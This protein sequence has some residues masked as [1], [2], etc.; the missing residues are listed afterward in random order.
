[1]AFADLDPD[2]STG[3]EGAAAQRVFL[4]YSRKNEEKVVALQAALETTGGFDVLRDKE[5]IFPA[6]D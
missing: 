2:A 3:A 6:E 4:S 1:M 5:D